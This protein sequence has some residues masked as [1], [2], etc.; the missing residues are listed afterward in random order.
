MCGNNCAFLHVFFVKRAVSVLA[1]ETIARQIE[2]FFLGLITLV[3]FLFLALFPLG[4]QC[5]VVFLVRCSIF[6]FGA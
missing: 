2:I 3:L 4:G 1:E 6:D 5:G